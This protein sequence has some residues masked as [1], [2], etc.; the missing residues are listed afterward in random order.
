M[1]LQTPAASL[2]IDCG[3]ALVA[4]DLDGRVLCFNEPAEHLM[5][6]PAA[7]VVG[8]SCW[9][10]VDGVDE[11]GGPFCRPEC[12]ILAGTRE[13]RGAPC[14]E[15]LVRTRV[16]RRRAVLSS[17]RVECAGTPVL[18]HVLQASR[19]A[20]QPEAAA[21]FPPALTAR[22]REV[23]ALL[24]E[25]LSTAEIASR[26]SVA[27]DTVRNH[28]RAIFLALGCHSRLGAVL[29]ARRRSIV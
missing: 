13:G 12:S 25:G 23:L 22:Q 18:L 6:I 14:L 28:I 29:E 8:K 21:G 10:I 4:I 15:L 27:R 7:E 11:S 20:F 5:G 16:G 17:L 3:D 9:E 26:L 1:R 19:P 2:T 24:A